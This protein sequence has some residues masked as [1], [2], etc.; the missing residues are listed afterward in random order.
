MAAQGP[1]RIS[2]CLCH[3]SLATSDPAKVAGLANANEWIIDWPTDFGGPAVFG[4]A[5]EATATGKAPGETR[6]H[7]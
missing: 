1:F 6:R 3:G 2:L 5:T 7:C 4:E